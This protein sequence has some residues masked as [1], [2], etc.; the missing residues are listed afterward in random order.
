VQARE[1]GGESG[2]GGVRPSR[3]LSGGGHVCTHR[4]RSTSAGMAGS[5]VRVAPDGDV[6]RRQ[7]RGSEPR[8]CGP[9]RFAMD[10]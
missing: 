1:G 6:Q 2:G 4:G 8:S 7:G 3:S 9:R 10:R 5:P